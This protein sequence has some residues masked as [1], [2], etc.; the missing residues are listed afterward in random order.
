MKKKLS[1]LLMVIAVL[2]LVSTVT[3]AY[4]NLSFQQNENNVV[5]TDCFRVTYEEDTS[6]NIHLERGYPI[7][8]E[9][10]RELK[11]YVFWMENICSSMAQYQINLE[12]MESSTMP[13]RVLKAKINDNKGVL[14]REETNPTVGVRAYKVS[15]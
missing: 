1:V 2:A 8:E 7:V 4:W 12:S 3:Y 9:E 6:S 15:V 5:V 13:E 11:P 10:G 14:L